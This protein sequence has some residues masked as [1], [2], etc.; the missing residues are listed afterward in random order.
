VSIA[1][2]H[3]ATVVGAGRRWREPKS[4]VLCEARSQ[5]RRR[6]FHSTPTEKEREMDENPQPDR[7][8]HDRAMTRHAA[9]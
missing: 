2:A 3:A 5:T 7:R 6:T 1:F 4:P 8:R 9:L